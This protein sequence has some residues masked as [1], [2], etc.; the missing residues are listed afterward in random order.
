VCSGEVS[1]DHYIAN[2][3]RALRANG[4]A[5][6]VFGLCGKESR[7]AGVECLWESERLQL[8]GFAEALTKLPNLIRLKNEIASKILDANPAAMVVADSPDFN[9][10]LIRGLRK[11]GY[12]GRIFY[13]SPP[14]VWAWRSYRVKQLAAQIDECMPLFGFEHEFLNRAG[15][16]SFWEGHPFVEELACIAP[17]KGDVLRGV[18]GGGDRRGDRGLVAVLPGSRAVEI[19]QLYG[20]LSEV[21]DA[22][23]ARGFMP[24]FSVA[25]GLSAR[26]REKLD[27]LLSAGNRRRFEGAGRELMAV[28]E[29]VV[30]SCGTAAVE[31]LLLRR[32]MVALYR[33][34]RLSGLIGRF[35]L[36]NRYFAMP[37]VLANE[38]FFPELIQNRVTP[39]AT[40]AA[41][42]A[43]LD[44]DQPL[45]A[46]VEKRMDE[47]VGM[48]GKPGAYRFWADRIQRVFD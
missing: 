38:E 24:V 18:T 19:D 6:R 16:N 29:L 41:S 47:V 25:P 13:I 12:R 44:A 30:G 17:E 33:L 14:T 46:K 3:Y 39:E 31:A 1:G 21:Y 11:K 43:W 20:V 28:S 35:V 36:H 34:G 37:N 7:E 9:L 27:A 5:Q 48:M 26:A 8:M 45:R 10:P 40:I 23:E 4:F 42:L 22:L 15:C 32:Y 2:T